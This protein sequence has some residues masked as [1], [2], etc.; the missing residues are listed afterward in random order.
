MGLM[1][2]VNLIK[3]FSYQQKLSLGEKKTLFIPWKT[4][5]SDDANLFSLIIALIKILFLLRA[6]KPAL[7]H[8]HTLKTNLLISIASSFFG[9]K[10]VFS[11]AGLGKFSNSKGLKKLRFIMRYLVM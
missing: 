6:L 1:L 8:S 3:L 11:F 4:R 7:I 5:R 2:S 9:I 10:T